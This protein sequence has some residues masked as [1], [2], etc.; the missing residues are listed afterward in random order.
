MCA[1]SEMFFM[2]FKSITEMV[3]PPP[4][5]T[6]LR[7]PSLKAETPNAQ[8]GI[9]KLINVGIG[10][11]NIGFWWRNTGWGEKGDMRGLP[12]MLDEP[13][14][15]YGF[16]YMTME[17]IYI[18]I[19]KC[20]NIYVK[21]QHVSSTLKTCTFYYMYVHLNKKCRHNRFPKVL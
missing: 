14:M 6:K 8:N 1:A 18:Y 10:W 11:N 15:F 19:Y 16:G 9:F 7:R 2:P 4:A 17:F 3:T 12:G 21:N 13:D 5:L 20:I